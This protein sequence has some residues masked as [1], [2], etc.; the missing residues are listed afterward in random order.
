MSDDVTTSQDGLQTPLASV[1][2]IITL[3]HSFSAMVQGVKNDL[4]REMAANAQASRERWDR[5]ER[6]FA[7]YQRD[8]DRRIELLE[9]QTKA[10]HGRLDSM[11]R[12][13]E[14][15]ELVWDSRV[16]PL[17]KGGIWLGAHYRDLLLVILGILAILGFSTETIQRIIGA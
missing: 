15:G 11:D 6:D 4:L 12:E 5:W 2:S 13:K 17:K 16:A 3:I 1:D 8:T 9:E 7:K 10:I 14:R